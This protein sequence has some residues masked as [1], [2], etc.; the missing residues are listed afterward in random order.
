MLTEVSKM[1]E[2]FWWSACRAKEPYLASG[3]AYGGFCAALQ[4]QLV[5][6]IRP[7]PGYGGVPARNIDAPFFL[8]TLSLSLSLASVTVFIIRMGVHSDHRASGWMTE[9][10]AFIQG[11]WIFTSS[12]RPSISQARF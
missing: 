8:D 6:R 4:I 12:R 10:G 1:R 11:A 5:R 3:Q 2:S 9:L 7:F